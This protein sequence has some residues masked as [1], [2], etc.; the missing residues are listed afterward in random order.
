MN[1]EDNINSSQFSYTVIV[2]TKKMKFLAVATPPSIYYGFYNWK[3]I[4]EEKFTPVNM[5][6]CVSQNVRKYK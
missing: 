2:V 4:W 1:R 5:R 3:T 6:S